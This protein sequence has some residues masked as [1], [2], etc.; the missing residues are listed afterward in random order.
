M[1]DEIWDE[2]TLGDQ[3]N[4]DRFRHP[5]FTYD[6]E[7]GYSDTSVASNDNENW[8]PNGHQISKLLNE[9]DTMTIQSNQKLSRNG[10]KLVTSNRTPPDV[11]ELFQAVDDMTLS[12]RTTLSRTHHQGRSRSVP[13]KKEPSSSDVSIL[14]RETDEMTLQPFAVSP[15]RRHPSRQ[16]APSRRST[17]VPVNKLN[18]LSTSNVSTM[19]R[20]ADEMTFQTLH[21]SNSLPFSPA[22]RG[23][24]PATRRVDVAKPKKQNKVSINNN[25]AAY[26][27]RNQ[28]DFACH[29][30]ETKINE[31]QQLKKQEKSRQPNPNQKSPPINEKELGSYDSKH[32][33]LCCG[34]SSSKFRYALTAVCVSIIA[35]F[36]AFVVAMRLYP[37]IFDHHPV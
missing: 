11:S 25:P 12:T 21:N 8:P 10:P 16:Q 19:L 3:Q 14:L 7:H 15:P 20:E 34:C 2:S 13:V 31:Q 17:S 37:T 24:P 27:K 4:S 28:R 9:V 35:G 26:P 32:R 18:K 5:L 29:Q 36:V 1:F 23:G 22:P 30:N 33:K 6:E